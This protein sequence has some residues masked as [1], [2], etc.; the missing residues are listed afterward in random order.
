MKNFKSVMM[1]E[2]M[3]KGANNYSGLLSLISF[4]GLILFWVFGMQAGMNGLAKDHVSE[5]LAQKEYQQQTILVLGQIRD[6]LKDRGRDHTEF[7]KQL[8]TN[9]VAVNEVSKA[10]V[11]I[12]FALDGIE[13]RMRVK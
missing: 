3:M 7:S 5:R 9:T 12:S 6:S 11:R 4:I 2:K 8:N 13:K 1:M 10:V